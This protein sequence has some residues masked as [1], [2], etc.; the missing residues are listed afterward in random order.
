[1]K[2]PLA[3]RRAAAATGAVALLVA[4]GGLGLVASRGGAG[5]TPGASA[6]GSSPYSSFAPTALIA[7]ATPSESPTE[8]GSGF[9]PIDMFS[10]PAPPTPPPSTP[11]PGPTYHSTDLP[12]HPSDAR[13]IPAQSIDW[14]KAK[15][16]GRVTLFGNVTGILAPS[17]NPLLIPGTSEPIPDAKTLDL[18]WTRWIV[19]PPGFGTDEKG[20]DYT[21]TSYW[22]LCGAGSAAV[23][24]YYWQA[25]TGYP[26][27]TGTAGWFVDPYAAEGAPWPSPGPA[28]AVSGG[29]PIGTYWSGSDSVGGFTAHG[30]GFVMYMATQSQPPTWRGTGMA[31]WA[32][33]QGVPYYPTRGSPLE[34]IQTG[35]NWEVS[36]RN[37]SNWIN[38]WYGTVN[39]WDPTLDRDLQVATML[40][41][42]RDGVPVVAAVDTFDLPNWQNGAS[43]PHTR[44]AVTIVGYDNTADPPT[45]TYIDT[46]GRTCNARGGNQN[47][48][49]HV[50]AQSAM[51][52]AIQDAVGIGFSW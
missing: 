42:G 30:R 2:A 33:D 31:I 38:A 39:S 11:K 18:S 51:V 7:M 19:E 50:I 47:G 16:A 13:P 29:K 45:F 48:Q 27:V 6:T 26:N 49:I 21:D 37:S 52:A 44:H 35:I 5:A 34:D 25:A 17:V 41:V 10:T 22:N 46:C 40:D 43:T 3:T 8:A 12:F 24:L 9:Q 4:M 28:V 20:T 36:N 15:A 1:M 14:M 32:D 23:T